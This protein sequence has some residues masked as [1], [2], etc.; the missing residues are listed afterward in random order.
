MMHTMGDFDST[1]KSQS[2]SRMSNLNLR[3]YGYASSGVALLHILVYGYIRTLYNKYTAQHEDLV[4][5]SLAGS[6]NCCQ[7]LPLSGRS[8]GT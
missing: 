5:Q 7:F 1:T 8:F 3:M 2:M 4:F 6:R